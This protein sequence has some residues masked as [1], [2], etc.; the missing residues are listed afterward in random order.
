MKELDLEIKPQ[1]LQFTVKLREHVN[2]WVMGRGRV[3]KKKC[4]KQE[5]DQGGQQQ[6]QGSTRSV[7]GESGHVRRKNWAISRWK[8][9]ARVSTARR[10][11]GLCEGRRQAADLWLRARQWFEWV[12]ICSFRN[13]FKMAVKMFFKSQS[14]EELQNVWLN[15][16]LSKEA[17]PR[18]Q[19]LCDSSK[20]D[21]QTANPS[22]KSSW[23][24]CLVYVTMKFLPPICQEPHTFFTG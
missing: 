15:S 18:T 14:L 23:Q 13:T 6:R 17:R 5:E 10:E 4:G 2:F 11:G 1:S 21:M 9:V 24:L 8:Q 7:R 20:T 22:A 19:S 16:L 3:K 12:A